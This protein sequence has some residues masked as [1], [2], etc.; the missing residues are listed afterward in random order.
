MY[1]TYQCLQGFYSLSTHA[2][3]CS[4]CLKQCKICTYLSNPQSVCRSSYSSDAEYL[5]AVQGLTA[6][7]ASCT[8]ADES[9]EVCTSGL[10]YK[11][12]HDSDVD[13]KESEGFQ[14]N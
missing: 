9:D 6:S 1:S 13:A 2:K 4:D 11:V 8:N 12:R 7:G 10:F 14:C 5:A 3:K